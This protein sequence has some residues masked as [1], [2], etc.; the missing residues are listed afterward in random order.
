M[1]SFGF[2]MVNTGVKSSVRDS[3]NL[4]RWSPARPLQQSHHTKCVWERHVRGTWRAR[5]GHVRGTW[6]AREDILNI[7][8]SSL[9]R[10]TNLK[11]LAGS[12]SAGWPICT[13]SLECS[14]TLYTGCSPKK[15]RKSRSILCY[16]MLSLFWA[17]LLY[18]VFRFEISKEYLKKISDVFQ[19]RHHHVSMGIKVM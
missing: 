16:E 8:E 4:L 3:I 7:S 13:V 2:L 12:S 15:V 19:W 9:L 6:E 10:A 14:R 11:P 17:A 5:E 1:Q 18:A